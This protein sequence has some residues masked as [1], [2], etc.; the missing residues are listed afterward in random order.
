MML[1]LCFVIGF[2][3]GTLIMLWREAKEFNRISD[4][5]RA[6][7]NLAVENFKR[8]AVTAREDA[9]QKFKD[10]IKL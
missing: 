8:Q 5:I 1:I 2:F 10:D 9:L 3:F 7:M 4:N 6:E